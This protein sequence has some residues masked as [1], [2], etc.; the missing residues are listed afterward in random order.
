MTLPKL[1]LPKYVSSFAV[2]LFVGAGFALL[3]APMPGKKMRRKVAVARPNGD[4]CQ[5]MNL[6]RRAKK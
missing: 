2:G 1:T 4:F 6:T 5:E 3:Y